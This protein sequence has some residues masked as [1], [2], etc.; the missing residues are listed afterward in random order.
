[1]KLCRY[2]LPLKI[3]KNAKFRVFN[4]L[5]FVQRAKIGQNYARKFEKRK[6]FL[7][8]LQSST[9][10]DI[11]LKFEVYVDLTLSFRLS[12]VSFF[13]ISGKKR[14]FLASKVLETQFL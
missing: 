13:L 11:D 4:S 6:V 14:R 9:F 3:R 5:S 1:M 8:I 7:K 10:Q 2:F 12:N